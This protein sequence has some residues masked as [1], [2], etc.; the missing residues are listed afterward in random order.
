[1]TEM[2]KVTIKNND[3]AEYFIEDLGIGVPSAGF[4]DF[5][6]QFTYD[7]ITGSDDLRF[8]VSGASLIVNDGLQDLPATSGAEYLRLVNVYHLEGDYYKKVD[9]ET[10]GES[11]VHWDN[12]SNAPDFTEGNTLD[13]SYD[14]GAPG[15]G[16]T[17][18]VD[19]GSVQLSAADGGYA[20]F[21]LTEQSILPTQGLSGGQFSVKDGILYIYDATR[22]KFLSVQRMFMAFGRKGKTKNQFIDHLAG[23]SNNSGYRLARNATI[24]SITGQVD[25]T[26]SC[27]IRIRKN[28]VSTNITS[29]NIASDIG[30]QDTTIDI[31]LS[32]GDYLQSFVDSIEGVS[33]PLVIVEIAWL[34]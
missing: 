12:I 31:N 29:L 22:T 9:L 30:D 26:G 2:W 34:G 11:E 33:D 21:E 18:L 5:H 25:E 20:P 16:R 27:D 19:T 32:A 28:D 8:A 17:V 4:I 7:D 24:V 3:S 6:E 10:S 13:G 23:T 14:Q 1:M 15:A